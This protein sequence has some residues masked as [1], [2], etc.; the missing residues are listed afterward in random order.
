LP[1]RTQPVSVARSAAVNAIGV[2]SCIAM[3]QPYHGAVTYAS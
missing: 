1:E 2:A 3:P